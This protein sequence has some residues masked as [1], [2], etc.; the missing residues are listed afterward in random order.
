MHLL[1]SLA[2]LL[3]H[4]LLVFTIERSA[5]HCAAL[6]RQHL[7]QLLIGLSAVLDGD[8]FAGAGHIVDVRKFVIGE[9]L[10]G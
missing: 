3:L 9:F 7:Q 10:G 8:D 5:E 6:G 4:F 2:I 1:F